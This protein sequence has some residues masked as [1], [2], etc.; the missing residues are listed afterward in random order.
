MHIEF[1]TVKQIKTLIHFVELI[2]I[3]DHTEIVK[4]VVG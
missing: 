3:S 1:T 2:Q 4:E